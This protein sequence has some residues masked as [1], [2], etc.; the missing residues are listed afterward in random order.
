MDAREPR[1]PVSHSGGSTGDQWRRFG[2][3]AL[4]F[5]MITVIIMLS[6]S[7]WKDYTGWKN[8][9]G[10]PSSREAYVTFMEVDFAL[11]V[12]TVFAAVVGAR[13]LRPRPRR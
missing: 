3:T 5:L 4:F 2:R 8:S 12:L 9:V 11:V 10:D 7:L 1:E 6:V 13:L